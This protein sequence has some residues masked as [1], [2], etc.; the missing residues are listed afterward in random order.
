MA[1]LP[2][3]Y[4]KGKTKLSFRSP[5]TPDTYQPPEV[6]VTIWVLPPVFDRRPVTLLG[7]FEAFQAV[8]NDP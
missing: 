6:V 8:L 4:L 2:F 5:G 1:L 3:Y 7:G